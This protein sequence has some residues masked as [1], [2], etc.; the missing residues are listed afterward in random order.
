M[1]KNAQGQI[2]ATE[3]KRFGLSYDQIL[4]GPIPDP[5][6]KGGI[7]TRVPFTLPL[8]AEATPA[9]VEALLTYALIPEPDPKLK[10]K[11]L[12][13]LK[14][15]KERAEATKLIQEY[16]LPRLLTFRTKTL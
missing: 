4:R 6:I 10:E 14:T 13:A 2:L 11:Y 9:S 7:T 16:A 8:A 5:L 1:L 12:A 15:D 3:Q